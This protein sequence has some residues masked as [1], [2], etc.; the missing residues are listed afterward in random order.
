MGYGVAPWKILFL[1]PML[2]WADL[3]MVLCMIFTHG[4]GCDG[5]WSMV[6]EAMVFGPCYQE[7]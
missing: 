2:G 5:F 1:D 7:I 4:F 3:P 6:L